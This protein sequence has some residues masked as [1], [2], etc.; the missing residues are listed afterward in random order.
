MKRLVLL[1]LTL[2]IFGSILL[3]YLPVPISPVAW[4]AP[5]N[6]GYVGD[7]AVNHKLAAIEKLDIGHLTGPEDVAIDRTGRIYAST[8]EGVI[9]RMAAD[10]STLEHWFSDLGRPLGIM[11]DAHDNLIVADAYLGLWSIS[12]N[13]EARLLTDVVDSKPINYA[14]NLDIASDGK[15]Y[16][17]DASTKFSAKEYG[18][19]YP[20][21]LL[22]LMEHGAH[23]RILCYDPADGSTELIIEGLN[24][25]NGVAL[26]HDEKALLINETGN[27]RVLRLALNGENKGQLTPFVEALPA[28]PDNLSRGLSGRYWLG[29]VSPRNRLLDAVSDK[30][31][32]RKMIQNL[33][34]F[35]RP[36]ATRYSHVIAFDEAGKITANLQDPDGLYATNTGVLETADYLYVG[37]LM[38]HAL[39][40][41][42]NPFSSEEPGGE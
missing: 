13:A 22:D 17:S 20:A 12:P 26:T 7:F 10:G 14:N 28:F 19:S 16:F 38:A 6:N 15:I 30:P 39:G 21:S 35:I 24:F 33:P 11:F 8:H 34:A 27:Y 42:I 37:S 18:G 25:A 36:Q 2:L 1:V 9:L 32:V 29:L 31:L 5:V 23:G 4:Q 3:L 40:R 41:L